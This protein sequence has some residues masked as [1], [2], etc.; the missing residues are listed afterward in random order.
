MFS[1][2]SFANISKV[3]YRVEPLVK[4]PEG[5]AVPGTSMKTVA[6]Q[7]LQ[8]YWLFYMSG[9]VVELNHQV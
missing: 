2:Y 4:Y 3:Q 9:V 5:V 6:T 8:L 1:T 7:G